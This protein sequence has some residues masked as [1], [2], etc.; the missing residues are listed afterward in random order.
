[1]KPAAFA[2]GFLFAGAAAGLQN[3]IRKRYFT[4]NLVYLFLY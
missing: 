4:G 1:M 2:A 3:P